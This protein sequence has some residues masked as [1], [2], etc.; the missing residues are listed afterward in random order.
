M[1]WFLLIATALVAMF[2]LFG[3]L[4][5]DKSA[6][7]SKPALITIAGLAF[8]A[9]IGLYALEGRP[10]LTGDTAAPVPDTKEDSAGQ[11]VAQLQQKLLSTNSQDPSGWQLLARSQMQI[12][13]YDEAFGSYQILLQLDPDNAD[14]QS[15]FEQAQAFVQ[16]QEMM[17][18]AQ[19]MSPE[20]QQAMI[21]NMVEGLASRIYEN[22]GT[23]EEW[24]R[25]IRARNV[26]GQ[27]EL[28]ADDIALMKQQFEDQPEVIEQILGSN[29]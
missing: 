3:P 5:S 13:Q 29:P 28:L 20:D 8:V 9:I 12:G 2:F 10:D 25:L 27:N 1:I 4:W 22:G 24:T 17:A 21:N 23:P 19:S 11:L 7:V 18:Q 15:E 26:L 16:R 14:Y 6:S